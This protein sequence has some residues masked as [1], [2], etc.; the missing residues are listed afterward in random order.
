MPEATSASAC[1]SM[2]LWSIAPA[3]EFQE[4]QPIG[5]LVIGAT[6]AAA[7]DGATRT[8]TADIRTVTAASTFH[9]VHRGHMF[10][11]GVTAGECACD[12]GTPIIIDGEPDCGRCER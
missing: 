12:N 1:C 11:G 7:L 6:A 9:S 5:G 10:R 2:T 3:K 4:F 8:M